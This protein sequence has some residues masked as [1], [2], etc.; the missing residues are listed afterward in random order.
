MKRFEFNNHIAATCVEGTQN[1][2]NEDWVAKRLGL[3]K[4]TIQ[5]WRDKGGG[6]P[7][8]KFGSAVRYALSDIEEY[9][10]AARRISTSD[11]G[12]GGCDA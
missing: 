1:Y 7:F 11:N 10:D 2:F 8:R 12:Q 3:S 9:E 6:P 5:S 4:K